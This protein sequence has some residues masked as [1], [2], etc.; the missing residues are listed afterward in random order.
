MAVVMVIGGQERA[1]RESRVGDTLEGGGDLGC[2]VGDFFV[3]FSGS[4]VNR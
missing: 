4:L 2:D 3:W 1:S